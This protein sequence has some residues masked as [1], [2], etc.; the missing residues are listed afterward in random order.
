MD[1][2]KNDIAVSIIVPCYK[3]EEYLPRCM[4]SLVNQTLENIEVIAINDGSPDNCIGILRD[5]ESR[6]PGKVVV[7]DKDNAGVWYGRQDGIRIARGEYIGF[8]D[9][10]DYADPRFA[11][12]LY[13][14]AKDNDADIA[15]CGFS[16]V[17]LETQ[18]V[19]ST[20]MVEERTPFTV[21]DDPGRLAELNGAP[22]NKIFR[23]PLLKNMHQLK[24]PPPVLDDLVFHMLVYPHVNTISY[25]TESLVSYMVRAGSIIQTVRKEQVD[26]AYGALLEVRDYYRELSVPDDLMTS[27][28][29]MAFQHLGVS[30][31]YRLSADDSCDF[32]AELKRNEAFLDE[33]FP[34]WRETPYLKHEYVNT[35]SSAFSKLRIAHKAYKAHLMG[36]FLKTYSFVTT[37]A[38][39]DI[40]W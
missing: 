32:S 34:A 22:W 15:V 30:F 9:S 24:E 21:S 28:D 7:I 26:Q 6:Y 18:K 8:L 37:K 13:T 10:D 33:N 27:L 23:A 16:R 1:A 11:E 29:T 14:S 5:Y 3:V 2:K 39:F 40:K 38:G 4:D 31:M 36:P 25:T 19:L 35:H 20:E 12:L 17:D